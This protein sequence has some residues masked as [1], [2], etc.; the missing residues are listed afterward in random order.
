MN[1]IAVRGKAR[2]RNWEKEEP[3]AKE[4]NRS[5][6][7]CST[8]MDREVRRMGAA[9]RTCIVI[10]EFAVMDNPPTIQQEKQKLA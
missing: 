7:E 9:R 2:F 4:G 6:I 10:S 5:V 3:L 8:I 1:M